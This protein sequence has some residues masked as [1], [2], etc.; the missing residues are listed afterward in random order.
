MSSEQMSYGVSFAWEKGRMYIDVI[1]AG[2]AVE[3]INVSNAT[4]KG[5]EITI[6]TREEFLAKCE[7][8]M[9]SQTAEDF[10]N[11]RYTATGFPRK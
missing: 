6:A 8:W 3:V 10:A 11:W 9:G 2:K 1:V 7:A 4:E 5:T